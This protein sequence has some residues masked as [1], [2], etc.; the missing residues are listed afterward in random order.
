MNGFSTIAYVNIIPLGFCDIMIGMDWLEKHHDFIKYHNNT[1]RCLYEEGKHSFV[2]GI[3]G[4]I[5]IRNISALETKRC[6][7]NVCQL[8]TPHVEELTKN[9]CPNIEY[10]VV[11]KECIDVFVDIPGLPPKRDIE[12]SIDLILGA[13]LILKNPY[14]IRIHTSKCLTSALYEEEEWDLRF[15]I[16]FR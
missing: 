8:F 2:K 7:K 3:L 5:S 13:S 4:P 14:T 1:F 10:F 9:N 11:L 16:E 12:F 15:F 6:L